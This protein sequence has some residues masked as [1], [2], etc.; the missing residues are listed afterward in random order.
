MI[1]VISFVGFMISGLV[2]L[3]AT[4]MVDS[5]PRS[6]RHQQIGTFAIWS[7]LFFLLLEFF[8]S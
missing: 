4:V 3:L 2:F 5:E 7:M 8:L 6:E 1:S